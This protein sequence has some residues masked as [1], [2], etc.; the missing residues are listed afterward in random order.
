[1]PERDTMTF[2]QYLAACCASMFAPLS[3]LL[4]K[5]AIGIAGFSGWLAPLFAALPLLLLVLSQHR[6]LQADGET[7]GL[8][9]ALQRR[10]GRIA[11]KTLIVLLVLWLVFY[12][13]FLLRSGAERLLSTVYHSGRLAFFLP[14]LMALSTVFAAGQLRT[15]GRCATVLLLL[16]AAALTLVF[17]LAVPAVHPENLWPPELMRC[18]EIAAAALPVMDVLSPWVYF[19]F[20]RGRV[21]EDGRSLRQGVF[22]MVR[23]LL[24][25]FLFLFSTIGILG[26]E[27]CQQLQYPFFTMTKNLTLFHVMERFDALVVVLWLMTDYVCVGMVLMSASEACCSVFGKGKRRRFVLPLAALMLSDAFLLATD[28]FRFTLFSDRVVP[29]VNLGLAFVLLPSVSLLPAKK[30]SKN[31]KKSVDKQK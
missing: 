18:G 19:S 21:T 27:L 13:G 4:P 28:A 10:M 20:L 22:G 11:G 15:A 25:A 9:E 30:I 31:F 24:L 14:A 5:A 16:F 1:M 12:G 17:L 2:R 26:A 8:A 23:M 3:R 7:V 29:A 6:L